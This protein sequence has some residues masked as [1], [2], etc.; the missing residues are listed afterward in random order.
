MD[1]QV[2][3][4]VSVDAPEEYSQED[5]VDYVRWN[6]TDLGGTLQQMDDRKIDISAINVAAVQDVTHLQSEWFTPTW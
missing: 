5:V 6:F 4:M 3:V 2:V 1:R